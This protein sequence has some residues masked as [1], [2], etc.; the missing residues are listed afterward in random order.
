MTFIDALPKT[1]DGQ[2]IFSPAGDF[3]EMFVDGTVSVEWFENAFLDLAVA[4]VP[5]TDEQYHIYIADGILSEDP[6]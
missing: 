3:N 5:L 1:E 4:T 6:A 2:I